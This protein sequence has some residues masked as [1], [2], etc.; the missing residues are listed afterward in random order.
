V[1]VTTRDTLSS[2]GWR[3]ARTANRRGPELV[4]P[5]VVMKSRVWWGLSLAITGAVSIAGIARAQRFE[6]PLRGLAHGDAVTVVLH[7]D[8]GLV[9]AGNDDPRAFRS[10]VLARS[11]IDWIDIPAFAGDDAEWDELVSCVRAEYAGIALEVVDSPPE[12]GDYIVTVIGGTPDAFGF[13]DAVGGI[14]P[15]N[16]R[17]IGDA[18]VF[19][20]QT[21]DT[22]SRKLCENVS[23]EIGHAL[24]LDHS[25]DCSDLMSYEN[26][27]PKHF[28]SEPVACGEW[29]DRGCGS[30]RETQASADELAQRV[31][32]EGIDARKLLP[33]GTGMS[34]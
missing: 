9:V 17:V 15:W 19:A 30:G 25:R 7:R 5:A 1:N 23:H 2:S 24:G 12:R 20:F 28:R 11:G 16:G 13:D 33:I 26:C 3:V 32:R 22:S 4:D 29:D 18:V 14:S 21:P 27:G 10:G 6:L 34:W 8:G 31:G